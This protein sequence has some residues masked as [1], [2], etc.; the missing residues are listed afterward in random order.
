MY[1][2]G[3]FS[4]YERVGKGVS[5]NPDN[6][7][8]LFRFL[9]IF[10]S[11]FSKLVILNFMF[12]LILLPFV[13]IMR[14]EYSGVGNIVFY[15]LFIILGAIV[16]PGLCGF[17][18]VLRNISCR[19]PVFIWYDFWKAF[20]TNFRQGAV[21]GMIDMLFIIA[22][23]FA[24]PMYYTMAETNSFFN[25]PFIICLITSFLFVMMHF[26]IYLLIASTNLSLWQILKNSLYLTAIEIKISIINLITTVIILLSFWLLFPFSAFTLVLIPS[27]LGLLYAFN[28]F[29][30]I[31]KYVI[32]PY[33]DARGEKMPD[34]SYTQPTEENTAVFIDTPETEIPQEPPKKNK[35][36]KIK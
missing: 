15:I 20:R 34:L 10:V 23:S 17:M 24:I 19:R 5:K 21:M 11:H 33:Y 26:Y 14:I 13:A 36:R 27:F 28:C 12:I 4:N 25:I 18:K 2:M 31:R 8:A 3:L 9:D 6:K 29:P 32:K 1:K 30:V 35:K 16:G 22:M 7:I